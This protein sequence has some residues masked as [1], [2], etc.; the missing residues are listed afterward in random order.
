MENFVDE[1]VSDEITESVI[2]MSL[3]DSID[4]SDYSLADSYD[5]E[6]AV[7]HENEIEEK[8]PA[9]ESSAN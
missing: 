3:E 6:V 8:S 1:T 4:D 2:E 9:K 7:V 5:E